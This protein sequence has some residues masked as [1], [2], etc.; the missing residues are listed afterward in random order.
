MRIVGGANRGAAL[1][2]PPGAATRPTTDRARETLFNILLHREPDAIVGARVLDLFAG[3]GALGLEA[4]SRGA[5]FALFVEISGPARAAIRRNV[6][7]LGAAGVTRVWRRS[8]S[9]LG[10]CPVAPFDC[11]FLDPPY[12]QGLGPQAMASAADGGW[13]KPGALVVLEE[14]EGASPGAVSG[15][16]AIDVR[17]IGQSAF[18]F[19]RFEGC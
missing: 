13:L 7:A 2:A 19:F 1:V 4:L 17:R 3:S 8:A 9:G 18:T 5:A 6:D 16:E 10:P 12:G 11:V 14:A 15:Y